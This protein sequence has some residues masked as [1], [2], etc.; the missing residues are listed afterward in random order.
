ML[1]FLW[2]RSLSTAVTRVLR[3]TL[4]SASSNELNAAAKMALLVAKARQCWW[5][6]FRQT[7]TFFVMRG[8]RP[9]IRPTPPIVSVWGRQHCCHLG[10]GGSSNAQNHEE[11]TFA[12]EQDHIHEDVGVQRQAAE[13]R[14]SYASPKAHK[15]R[16]AW[17]PH[18]WAT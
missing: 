3:M 9:V 13:G 1:A 17:H 14:S 12:A 18:W 16:F 15:H 7:A 11:Y 8:S 6:R 2:R 4:H 5:P 10:G